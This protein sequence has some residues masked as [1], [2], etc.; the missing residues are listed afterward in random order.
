MKKLISALWAVS[1][2]SGSLTCL[3]GNALEELYVNGE[4]YTIVA[5]LPDAA[6]Y[7]NQFH[8]D[9]FSVE[10]E[11]FKYWLGYSDE[12][13]LSSEASYIFTG[14][15]ADRL[16]CDFSAGARI[17]GD[18]HGANSM[19]T[20]VFY[21]EGADKP[22]FYTV[23]CFNKLLADI[24]DPV[25]RN[26]G[27]YYRGNL[28]QFDVEACFG[29]DTVLAV[30][31]LICSNP[32][33]T[34]DPVTGM[35]NDWWPSELACSWQYKERTKEHLIEMKKQVEEGTLT[36]DEYEMALE[37]YEEFV[38]TYNH[39]FSENGVTL[40]EDTG[41]L[42]YIGH[43]VEILGEDF[44]KV[45]RHELIT[46]PVVIFNNDKINNSYISDNTVFLS[47]TSAVMITKGDATEDDHVNIVDVIAVNKAVLGKG[48]LNDYSRL[49][50]DINQDGVPDS[51]DSLSI[52]K[53]V[54]GLSD[55]LEET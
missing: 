47:D 5:T 25:F 27:W 2:L 14:P 20:G 54:V 37:G 41:R 43:G 49:A 28:N 52:L 16:A 24:A 8:V 3:T 45:I 26:A 19:I 13:K 53:Y 11:N 29:K 21:E 40:K 6:V 30:G 34:A 44:M 36:L 18:L 48:T 12:E 17:E 33:I 39:Y 15:F 10:S 35:I 38:Y 9:K 7:D 32:D 42:K 50:T 22:S 55:T 1:L 51:E 4:K 46:K 23:V 31:D